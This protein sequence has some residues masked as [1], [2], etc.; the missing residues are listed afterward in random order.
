MKHIYRIIA[1]LSVFALGIASVSCEREIPEEITGLNLSRCLEPM[2]LSAKVNAAKGDEVTFSWNVTKDADAFELNIYSDEGMTQTVKSVELSPDEVPYTIKLTADQSYYFNVRATSKKKSAS[3]W[4]TYSDDNV[5]P[6]SIKTYA[7][8]DPLYMKVMDRAATSL[9]FSWVADPEVTHIEYGLPGESKTDIYQL[10]SSEI[11]AGSATVTG[12]KASTQYVSTLYYLSASR[13]EVT[14][15]TTPDISGTTPVSSVDA[16]ANALKTAGAKILLKM[17]GSPYEIAALDVSNGVSILG[18][19]SADGT[20]PVLNGELHITDSFDGG[21]LYF[22]GVEFNGAANTY[23]FALQHKNGATA[24]GVK[25]GSIIYKNCVITGYSKGI[26]YEWGKTLDIGEFTYE[27]CDIYDVNKDGSGGGD[28]F[29]VRQ[30]TKIAKLNFIDNTIWNGFR[31]FLRIDPNPVI[32]DVRF[33]NNTVMNLCFVDNTNNAGLIAFQTAP[34]GEFSFKKNL[35]LNMVEKATM[36]SA[37]VKY[38]PAAELHLSA[39]DNWYCNIAETFF[40]DNFTLAAAA[41]KM[42]GADPC[43]NAKAGIFNILPDSEIAGAKVGASKWWTAYTKEPEDLTLNCLEGAHTWDLGNAKF[44]SGTSKEPMVRDDLMIVASEARPVSLEGGRITFAD[45]AELS[46]KGIPT[47]G[48]LCFKVSKP[49]SLVI[50]P[51]EGAGNHVTIAVSPVEGGAF[52][53][54]GG[55]A[56]MT[57]MSTTQKILISDITGE[58]MIYVYPSGAIS[59]SQIAWSEDVTQ[60]NTALGTPAPV[61][62]PASFTQ[63]EPTDVTVSWDPVPNAD[64]YSA[65]FN[66]KTYTVGNEP[67]EN[68]KYSYTVEGKTTGML[69]AGSYKVE[70]FANPGEDDIY[71]TQSSA[72]TAVFAVLPKGGSDDDDEV[73]VKDVESLK[74]AIDAGKTEITLATGEFDFGGALNVTAPLAL[75]GQKGAVVKGAFTLE[76]EVGTFSLKGINFDA[77]GQ[78]VFITPADN[79]ALTELKVTDCVIDGYSKSVIYGNYDNTSID[80]ISFVGITVSNQG[81]SQGM[82]DFRK[83]KYGDIRILE[84]TIKGGRDFLRADASTAVGVIIVSNNTLDG[85]AAGKNGNGGILWVRTSPVTYRVTNN[86][87]LNE[88]VASTTIT[89]KG[90]NAT[91]PSFAGNFYYLLADGFSSDWGDGAITENGGAILTECPVKD[92]ASGDY[93]LVSGL[94]MSSKAGASKWNPSF[95]RGSTESFEVKSA[96]EFA[97]ALEAGKTDI[98]LLAEGSPYALG[99]ISAVKGLRITGAG[100]PEITGFIDIAGEDLGDIVIDGVTFKYDGTNGCAVNVSAASSAN[101]LIVRNC[102]FDGFSKSVLYDNNKLTAASVVF[103]DIIVKNHGTGQGVFDLRKSV[104]TSFSIEHSTIT[105]G[106]DLVRADAGTVT[107]AFNFNNNTVDASNLGVNGNAIM[108]VRATP[109]VFSFKNNLFLNEIAEGKSV[110]LSKTSGVTIPTAASNNFFYNYDEANFFSGLFNKETAAAVTLSYDPV[111]DA[112]SG[113]YTLTDALCLSSNIGARR[114]NPNA[115]RVTTEFTVSNMD[116]LIAALDAGKTSITL[117]Y[118]TYDFTAVEGNAAFSSGVFTTSSALTLKGEKKAGVGPEIIGA[119]KFGEGTTDFVA[120]GLRFNGKEKAIGNTFEV[121]VALSVGK[122]IIR[123]C[124]I[125]DFNKSLFYGNAD[126]AITSLLF[127]RLSVHGFGTG[128]GMFDIRKEM[129]DAVI[130]RNSTFYNGGRDFIRLDATKAKSLSI[131]NNT[132]AAVSLE[133]ANSILYVRADMGDKY[134]VENNL[135]LNETGSATILAKSGTKVP[136]MKNNWFFNCSSAAFWG[137]TISQEAATAN[138]GG[139]LETDPCTNSAEFNFKLT[140]ASLKAAGVGDPRWK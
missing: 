115:G 49:G 53:T 44:F 51:I 56:E 79:T 73:I 101:K 28:G 9:T 131:K 54:K 55:A 139:I 5:R 77:A 132:F 90:G 112:A 105:G 12:L 61:A 71:N 120:E 10:N 83:G 93:T 106:R 107:A 25:V 95:D 18:E 88:D 94:V 123:D 40:T 128:Q 118:G 92:A 86:L 60:V 109:G 116:E 89:K 22:E 4:V 91:R 130:I 76:G 29:D 23:G 117:K 126:G 39:A 136:V 7:V 119:I 45:A 134:V 1:L 32:G 43:Y 96:D 6:K 26:F 24:D 104:L 48:Y 67:D 140:D 81:T 68:G 122:I 85:I 19:E 47:D 38:K 138:G 137:G 42:L 8:K 110:L 82:F 34:T 20:K 11:A 17:E 37:N 52:T 72:G 108:Y 114:W 63:G 70:I 64:S 30:A 36:A 97:A 75:K 65:V 100:M 127:D 103:N 80:K 58:S 50:R 124:E 78:G 66:G 2:E 98:K 35:F 69:D 129:Y 14:C 111:K 46:K 135:F 99:K 62:A 21:N 121:P 16:L 125:F 3:N 27:S 113:D 57:D 87:F 74:A 15:W 102:V 31:T 84:S 33:E 133:A 13:G 41:G 59:L